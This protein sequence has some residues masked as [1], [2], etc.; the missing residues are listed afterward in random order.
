MG[1]QAQGMN[2][3]A[4]APTIIYLDDAMNVVPVERATWAKIWKLDGGIEFASIAPEPAVPRTFHTPGGVDHDQ[5]LH[6]NWSTG[7]MS[8]ADGPLPESVREAFV[9]MGE[10][11]RGIPESAMNAYQREIQGGVMGYSIEH[12]GDLSH[13]MTHMLKWGDGNTGREYIIEKID[14]IERTLTNPY[15]FDKEH[16]EN[17]AVNARL[18]GVDLDQFRATADSLLTKYADAHA[19]L[20]V[21]NRAQWLARESAIQLGRQNTWNA[22]D[23]MRELRGM[24]DDAAEWNRHATTYRLGPD[25]KPLRYESDR[26][27]PLAFHTP[28]GQEH[29]QK[30]HGNWA[31]GGEPIVERGAHATESALAAVRDVEKRLASLKKYEEAVTLEPQTGAVVFSKK[32]GASEVTFTDE[33][34]AKMYGTI[35]THNHPG[36]MSLSQDDLQ[37][38]THVNVAQMRATTPERTYVVERLGTEWPSRME[39]HGTYNRKVYERGLMGTLPNLAAHHALIDAVISEFPNQL[40]YRVE[41][42]GV[43]RA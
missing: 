26:K 8:S 41:G 40:D 33:E 5:K 4:V 6:G 15:G 11:Q 23:A 37:F 2:W 14:K 7:G 17:L 3:S 16:G 42:K 29:D 12:V 18:D 28:G 34:A 36:G 13:R 10:Q 32:G 31:T 19:A 20:P 22:V 27:P 43:P 38:A 25:G 39:L 35:F 21:Y 30:T 1:A 24:A 9:A